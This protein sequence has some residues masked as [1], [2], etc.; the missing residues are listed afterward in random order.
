MPQKHPRG[1]IPSKYFAY[2]QQCSIVGY[3][4]FSSVFLI[5]NKMYYNKEKL[6]KVFLQLIIRHIFFLFIFAC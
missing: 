1:R 5:K 3:F 2:I 6:L 4:S